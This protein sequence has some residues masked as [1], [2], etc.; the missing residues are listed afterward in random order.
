MNSTLHITS[1]DSAGGS[2]A[3]AG[4]PGEVFVW[5]DVLYDGPRCPGWPDDTTLNARA[6]FLED[7]T[8]GGLDRQHVIDTLRRQYRKLAEAAP[9]AH[10]VLWFDACLF[11]QSMLAH[12]LMCLRHRNVQNVELLCVDEFP[13][14]EPY[15]GL[16]Q[17][18]P[19]QLASLYGNRQPVT[20]AQFDFAVQVDGAF[21]TQDTGV[22]IEL[23]K[24]TDAPL[25]WIPAAVVRWLQERPDSVTGLGRLEDLAFAAIRAGCD[26]PCK[27]F[28]S[29]AA[30][31][32]P[33][34][35]WGDTTLWAKINALAEREPPLVKIDGPADRLPQWES[36]VP[37]GEF[38][39]QALPAVARDG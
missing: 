11:D 21:A 35:F 20:D 38:R 1:G 26:T 34:Q 22:L 13:G 2:L 37:L 7:F 33:P 3:Q 36:D 19:D 5:H 27:I 23:S 14:I 18:Q 8:A 10:I 15:H 4:L 29:V 32:T 12:I 17:L 39:I 24:M 16:G 6:E 28:V 9:R 31:D 30:S 25:P